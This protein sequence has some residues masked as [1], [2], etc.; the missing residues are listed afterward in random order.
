[1]FLRLASVEMPLR[2]LV[3]I[4]GYLNVLGQFTVIKRS[5]ER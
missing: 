3:V 4:G 2:L 1:M 5:V